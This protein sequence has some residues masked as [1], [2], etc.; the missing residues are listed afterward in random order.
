MSG[1]L[2]T[3]TLLL[4]TARSKPYCT[5]IVFLPA[6]RLARVEAE[7][8]FLQVPFLLMLSGLPSEGQEQAQEQPMDV[9][10][11]VICSTAQQIERFVAL[12]SEGR[13]AAVALRTV[14][15]EVQNATACSLALVMFSGSKSIGQLAVKGKP[16]SILEITVHAFGNGSAWKQTPAIVQYTVVAEKGMMI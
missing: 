11:G 10:R 7:M 5:I 1:T 6:R 2:R 9:G 4:M 14:N 15:D 13:E 12:E 3:I 8:R 16:V